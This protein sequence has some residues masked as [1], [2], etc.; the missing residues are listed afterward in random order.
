ML[1]RPASKLAAFPSILLPSMWTNF[2]IAAA[3]AS[4]ALAGLVIVAI[5]VNIARIL[6]Y[7]HLPARSAATV[8][9]LILILVSSMAALIPQPSSALGI[10]ILVFTLAAWY[11]E[12]R[13]NRSGFRARAEI[14]RPRS[15]SLLESVL[16]EIQMLPFLVGAILLIL[17]RASAYY[18]IAAGVIAIFIFSTLNVRIFLVEILR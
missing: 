5:S 8:A 1:H 13:S 9:R 14:G 15:E 4:A 7:P 2:F 16:G 12:I 6:E 18:C 3:S 10:E 11:L 17:N